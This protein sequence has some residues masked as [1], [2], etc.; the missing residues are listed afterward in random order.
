MELKVNFTSDTIIF[1]VPTPEGETVLYNYDIKRFGKLLS[2]SELE[3]E[4]S[5]LQERFKKVTGEDRG[6]GYFENIISTVIEKV[7]FSKMDQVKIENERLKSFL[8]YHTKTLRSI[9]RQ[10]EVSVEDGMKYISDELYN[11]T[12]M[13]IDDLWKILDSITKKRNEKK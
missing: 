2:R 11:I 10:Y 8:I 1:Y 7:L 5:L 3:A 12:N 13:K 4:S 6:L 9:G